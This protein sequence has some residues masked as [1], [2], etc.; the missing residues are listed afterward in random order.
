MSFYYLPSHSS[1][2]RQG[3]I[4][5]NLFELRPR[6]LE[7]EIIDVKQNTKLVK[8]DHPYAIVASQDCDLEWDYKARQ[9]QAEDDKLL[10][11]VLFCDL[12]TQGEIYLRGRLKSDLRRRVRKNQDERYHRLNEAPIHETG[13]A[14]PELYADFKAT[15]SLPV[16]FV[17]RL[18]SSSQAARRGFLP[19]P[20]L[21]DFTHRL[22]NFL[23]RV[24][25]PEQLGTEDNHTITSFLF[26][27]SS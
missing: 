22:Y 3:E 7:G 6:V 5:E 4:I 27:Q 21:Q 15:F 17:Y 11:H 26:R 2:L 16:E 18:I 19:H 12:F 25:L 9:G 20:Y 8:I 23:G 14:L 24:A 1:W 10:M 13:Q